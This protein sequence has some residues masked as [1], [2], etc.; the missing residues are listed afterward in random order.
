MTLGR[1]AANEQYKGF[2]EIIECLPALKQQI[3]N[4]AYL[5]VG[6]GD[7]KKR[8][9]D[10]A[11]ALGVHDHVIF[12]GYIPE[13]EK[14]NHYRLADA[15]VMPGR[16]EGFG[17]VYLEAMACGIPTVGS[18]L[19]GSRDALRNG[20]LGVLVDPTNLNDIHKAILQVLAQGRGKIPEGLDYFS[21]G[22]FRQRIFSHL[23]QMLVSHGKGL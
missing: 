1:L 7:D 16:G 21:V 6:D 11:K 5:I 4:I 17:I 23:E 18:K 8:L 10:K 19:D 15:Y 22:A 2:D 14:S 12:A 13:S 3:P 20:Q 9:Q